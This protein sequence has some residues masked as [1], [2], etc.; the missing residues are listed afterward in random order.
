MSYGNIWLVEGHLVLVKAWGAWDVAQLHAFDEHSYAILETV[1]RP[2]VHVVFEMSEITSLPSLTTMRDFRSRQHP[3]A[4]WSLYVGIPNTVL[5]FALSATAQISKNRARFLK[6]VPEA[7][8]FI[9]DVD[10]TLPDL[11]ELDLQ[12]LLN[13]VAREKIVVN[14]VY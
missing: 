9:E 6:T 1:T 14:P 5:R 4:G 10:S 12:T 3:K 7:L 11:G 8:E 13:R 2:M